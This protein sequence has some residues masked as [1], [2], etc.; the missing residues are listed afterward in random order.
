MSWR[1]AEWRRLMRKE[2]QDRCDSFLIYVLQPTLVHSKCALA[3]AQD[4]TMDKLSFDAALQ[5]GGMHTPLTLSKA[6]SA[7]QRLQWLVSRVVRSRLASGLSRESV[8]KLALHYWSVDGQQRCEAAMKAVLAVEGQRASTD[9]T[10]HVV[11]N[12]AARG[13]EGK[14]VALKASLTSVMGQNHVLGCKASQI[15]FIL[16]VPVSILQMCTYL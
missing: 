13:E 7:A 4:M 16:S 1:S 11:S 8:E 10:Y 9:H 15:A 6:Q 5:A 12:L 14:F 2:M 3:T